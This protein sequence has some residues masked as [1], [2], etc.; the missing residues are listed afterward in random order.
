MWFPKEFQYAAMIEKWKKP[1]SN[2]K[3]FGALLKDLSNGFDC[4]DYEF[5]N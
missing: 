1:V 3:A 2:N 4:L 5:P